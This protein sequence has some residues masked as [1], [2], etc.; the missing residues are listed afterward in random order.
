MDIENIS[1][2]AL[3][4][5]NA[6]V[7]SDQSIL[8]KPMVSESFS[9]YEIRLAP[10]DVVESVSVMTED[11]KE[12]LVATK[13]ADEDETSKDNHLYAVQFCGDDKVASMKLIYAKDHAEAVKIVQAALSYAQTYDE[14]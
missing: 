1:E 6:V 10:K 2:S 12:N 5:F 9:D 7:E 14:H 3:E 4:L 13:A 8:E 11:A